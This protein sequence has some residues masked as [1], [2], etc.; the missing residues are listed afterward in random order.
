M[1]PPL[2]DVLRSV[3]ANLPLAIEHATFE[4]TVNLTIGGPNWSLNVSGCWR[5]A[6]PGRLLRGSDQ[7]EQPVTDLIGLSIVAVAAQSSASLDPVFE[8][9]DGRT[10]ELFSCDSFEPW[11]LRL[12]NSPVYVSSPS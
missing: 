12:P 8:L 4:D 5:L 1:E 3:R 2:E 9:A 7:T 6:K 11:V 10:L